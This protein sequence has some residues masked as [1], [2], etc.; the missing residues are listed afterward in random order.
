ME[1][2]NSSRRNHLLERFDARD[3]AALRPALQHI[4]LEYNKILYEAGQPIE[5]VY[6]PTFGVASMV[7]NMS[8]GNSS[9]VGTIGNEGVVGTPIL[10]GDDIGSATVHVEVPG[11]GLRLPA[12]VFRDAI[13]R[14]PALHRLMQK[15]AF[16]Y[17]NQVAQLVACNHFHDVEQ[18]CARWLLMVQ[19]RM[20]GADFP[21][22][23]EVLSLMLGV[24]RS[25]VTVAAGRLSEAGLI[26]YR[27]GH[28]TI[29]DR[30][31][32]EMRSCECYRVIRQEYE[33]LVGAWPG[34]DHAQD[35][36]P[37]HRAER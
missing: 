28:M 12:R 3:E 25:S 4:K 32:L 31:G 5:F 27:R 35:P 2:I 7:K 16:A 6:F 30:R 15:Y 14:S 23:H 34:A 37:T 17:F 11:E 24:R 19:D 29:L 9:E 26:E 18:R 13:G 8:D 10:F 33:R 36:L 1:I 21:L 20:P 22:T